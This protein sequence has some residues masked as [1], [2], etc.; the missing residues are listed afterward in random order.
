MT[1]EQKDKYEIPEIQEADHDDATRISDDVIVTIVATVL[2]EVEGV[3]SVPGGIVSG[4]LGRKGAAKG[5]KVE[6]SN[7]EVTIDLA[8]TLNYG[9]KIPDVAAEIQSKI[10][11]R[12]EEMTGMYVRAVNVSVQGMR[13]PE[14]VQVPDEEPALAEEDQTPSETKDNKE[15]DE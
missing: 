7:Q 15:Q 11:E 14:T 13:F 9:I 4:I 5:I 1:Q 2:S 12:V 3:A 8:V 10:R 6:A